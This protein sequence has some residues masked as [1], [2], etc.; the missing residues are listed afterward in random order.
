V[1]FDRDGT[2]VADV[3]YNGDPELVVAMPGARAAVARL[4]AAGVATAAGR[5]P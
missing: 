2:L 4:R 5:T 3:P 1:L